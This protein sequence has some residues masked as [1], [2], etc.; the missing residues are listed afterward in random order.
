M[1]NINMQNRLLKKPVLS[2]I[3]PGRVIENRNFNEFILNSVINKK[4]VFFF[5]S[6]SKR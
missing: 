2:L 6:F 1:A 5:F 4:L 3:K